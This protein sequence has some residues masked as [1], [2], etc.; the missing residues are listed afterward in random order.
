MQRTEPVKPLVGL[1]RG[2]TRRNNPGR[3][4]TTQHPHL[5]RRYP[6]PTKA[7]SVVQPTPQLRLPRDEMAFGTTRATV[8]K[9]ER[10]TGAQHVCGARLVGGERLELPT[11]TV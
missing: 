7:H 5:G 3:H 8:P 6:C 1:H 11:S 4:C 2:Q 9:R 10:D